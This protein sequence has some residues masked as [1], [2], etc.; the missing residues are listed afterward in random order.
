MSQAHGLRRGNSSIT[1]LG[2]QRVGTGAPT[3]DRERGVEELKAMGD[4]TV[5]ADDGDTEKKIAFATSLLD[6]AGRGARGHCCSVAVIALE[7]G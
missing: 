3:A 6:P 2:G 4:A 1:S 7:V 5:T